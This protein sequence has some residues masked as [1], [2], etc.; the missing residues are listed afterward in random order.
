MF[1]AIKIDLANGDIKGIKLAL[2]LDVELNSIKDLARGLIFYGFV[3]KST[4]KYAIPFLFFFFFRGNFF[5]HR[6][7]DSRI[8]RYFRT[9]HQKIQLSTINQR[10]FNE[11]NIFFPSQQFLSYLPIIKIHVYM[12][13]PINTEDIYIFFL[14]VFQIKKKICFS[15]SIKLVFE[16]CP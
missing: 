15:F 8:R 4:C 5:Y 11:M 2:K 3:D 16:I 12:F 1:A 6:E 7:K 13:H 10:Q 14:H 9:V